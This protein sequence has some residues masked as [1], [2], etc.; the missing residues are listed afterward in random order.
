M[1]TLTVLHTDLYLRRSF[2][3]IQRYLRPDSVLFLG[4]LFDGG[5]EWGAKHTEDPTDAQFKRYGNKYWLKEY[6]RFSKLFF[7]Q[8]RDG[9]EGTPGEPRGRKFVAS[10]P[11][12][13]D[14]GFATGIQSTVKDRFDAYFGP[15]NRLDIVGNH[16]FVSVDSVSLS[17]MDQ[18]DPL[19]GSSG[20]GDGT[21]LP[22]AKDSIW[23]PVST[24][25]DDIKYTKA[26]AIRSELRYLFSQPEN[27]FHM[28]DLEGFNP[29]VT[30]LSAGID[31]HPIRHDIFPHAST[32]QFPTILLTHVPLYRQ[33]ETD[34]GPQRER[35]NAISISSGYQYQN[36]LTPLISKEIISSLGAEEVTQVYSGDDHDY[37]E[38]L[39]SEYSGR[40]REVTVKSL[41]WAMGVRRPGFVAVSLYNPIDAE[42]AR[43][44]N[45]KG[46]AGS[47]KDTVQDH[48]CLLPD[49]LSIF[50]RY[51]YVL[52]FTLATLAIRS[53]TVHRN[54][55]TT[56]PSRP[57]HPLL[58]VSSED[59][60][61]NAST[62]ASSLQP[63]HSANTSNLRVGRSPSPSKARLGGY[64]NLPPSSRSS[65]PYKRDDD[66]VFAP[67]P[68]APVVESDDWGM[69]VSKKQHN[70]NRG[71]L[72]EFGD[73]V[74]K[75]A[76]PVLMVYA[77]LV[78]ND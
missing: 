5:R 55:S 20:T 72:G 76:W 63:S 9:A 60:R 77:W 10:L 7:S 6:T 33:P 35:G 66:D 67:A 50:I 61:L 12:N 65:S 28:G 62:S 47:P 78:W 45:A 36:V 73:S 75:V 58:P 39:H 25:L 40:V 26:R 24:F 56:K 8:W 22:T 19:T 16:T 37:C 42:G 29:N 57:T 54:A 14:L 18:A 74:W 17:A 43:V 46:E 32:S 30:S 49:Q 48:L 69:P 38:V 3:H 13:H 53:I 70:R 23:Q 52:V 68:Y 51:A 71:L 1:S 41:S 2:N 15:L 31:H 21:A 64:G 4:D 59:I 44:G 11:G 34:C 27:A